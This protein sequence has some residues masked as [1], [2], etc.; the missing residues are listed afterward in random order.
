MR[1]LPRCVFSSRRCLIG[2]QLNARTT[3]VP[4]SDH[5]RTCGHGVIRVDKRAARLTQPTELQVQTPLAYCPLD[6]ECQPRRDRGHASLL[7]A[8]ELSL[9]WPSPHSTTSACRSSCIRS[10]RKGSD[11]FRHCQYHDSAWNEVSCE[12]LLSTLTRLPG[13]RSDHLRR[14]DPTLIHGQP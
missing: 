13:A 4:N 1:I 2:G 12:P 14:G 3:H 11:D 9:T 10:G 6:R 5:C 8:S 7:G